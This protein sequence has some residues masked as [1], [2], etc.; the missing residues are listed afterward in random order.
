[1]VLDTAPSRHALEFLDYP[2]R[3]GR[4]LEARTLEWMVGL[5]KLAGSTLDDR[6]DDDPAKSTP[7]GVPQRLLTRERG[8]LAWG[9]KR[10]GHMVSNLVGAVA[11]R[12][13][14]ALFGEFMPVREKWLHL[15]RNVEKRIALPSTRYVVVTGPSGSSLDDAAYLIGQLRERSLH[16][17]AVL[18]NRAVG[19]A[20][21][22]LGALE[23]KIASEPA[24]GDALAAY[25][26]EYA[27][28]EAQTRHALGALGGMVP[29][30]TPLAALP[31]LKSSDPRE[32]LITIAGALQGS[33]LLGGG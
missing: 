20:P 17:S 1:M 13:I 33:A 32:I 8:L 6:P 5:A 31:A 9:K 15:V 18:L 2:G 25:R 11:V 10:V 30:K 29:K 26:R 7:S 22:W 24:L 3:L 4:M 12:D 16:A 28:R 14:A 19:T 23:D 21:A 27:A